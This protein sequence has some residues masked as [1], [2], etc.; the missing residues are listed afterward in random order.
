VTFDHVKKRQK[1]SK[2]DQNAGKNHNLKMPNRSSE[3]MVKFKH[4]GIM[5]TNKNHIP[6]EI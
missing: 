1:T 2:A 4:L 5:I 6:E 3:N